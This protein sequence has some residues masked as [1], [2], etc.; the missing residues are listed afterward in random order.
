MVQPTVLPNPLTFNSLT[1]RERRR[2]VA[3]TRKLSAMLGASPVL[4]QDNVPYPIP[5]SLSANSSAPSSAS[6]SRSTTPDSSKASRRHASIC[7]YSPGKTQFIYTSPEGA[8]SVVSLGLS[9]Q[10]ETGMKTL[11]KKA[12]MKL[13]STTKGRGSNEL[14]RPLVLRLNA[15]PQPIS[16]HAPSSPAAE[17]SS[18]I[19]TPIPST[20]TPTASP[21][22]TPTT[23]VFPSPTELR[24]KRMAKL[25]RTLGEI[26]PPY[27]VSSSQRPSALD[28]LDSKTPPDT[29]VRDHTQPASRQRRSMSVDYSAE[30]VSTFAHTSRVWVTGTQTWRGEWN[31]KDIKDVQKQLRSLK[32]R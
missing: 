17:I 23:P 11:V 24:R 8:S 30:N 31:R 25:T 10:A 16:V 21:A 4:T 9:D 29:L 26:I 7:S 5:V 2:L 28:E 1:S 12:S 18:G 20:P 3:S 19:L 13:K 14:P 32:S 6:S 27:L 22:M 15:I